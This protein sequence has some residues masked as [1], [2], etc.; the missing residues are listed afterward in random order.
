VEHL[1][2]ILNVSFEFSPKVG[3]RQLPEL[4]KNYQSTV[5]GLY[6]VGDLADAP[7]IKIA[8]NQGY[9]IARHIASLG[10]DDRFDYDCLIVG[11][12]PAGIGGCLALKEAGRRYLCVEKETPFN[13]IQNFPKNKHIFAEP[14]PI[15]AKSG[16]WF[17]DALKEDLVDRWEAEL[18]KHGLDIQQPEEVT[19]IRRAG[20]GFEVVT[21]KAK[22]KVRYV[23]LAIGRRGSVRRA[24]VDGEDLEKVKYALDDADRYR[25]E[26]VMVVGGGDSAVEAALALGATARSVRLCHRGDGFER[27]KP[28]NQQKLKKA[29]DAGKVK[30]LLGCRLVR[31]G[32]RDVTFAA[33]SA[34]GVP[35]EET[36]ANQR[37][38]V[39]I[40]TDLPLPFLKKIGVK[41]EGVWDLKRAAWL[42]LSVFIA[43]VFYGMKEEKIWWPWTAHALDAIRL[44]VGE[45]T[46]GGGFWG[47]VTYS[48]VVTIFGLQAVKK[49]PARHQKIRFASL[50]LSQWFLLFIIPEFVVPGLMRLAHATTHALNNAWR[51]YGL[52]L[53]WPLFTYNVN[54]TNADGTGSLFWLVAG[55]LVTLV[56][57]PI[58]TIFHGKRFCTWICGCGALAETLGDRW[59]HLAPKGELALKLEKMGTVILVVCAGMSGLIVLDTY[60]AVQAGMFSSVQQFKQHYYDVAVD[61]WLSGAIPVGLYP[62][63]G[64]K[65][66]C[67]FWC[68][69]AKYMQITSRL[70]GKLKIQSNDKCIGCGQCSRYCQVGIDVQHFAQRQKPFDNVATSCIQCGICIQV[71]PMDVLSFTTGDG[72]THLNVQS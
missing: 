17:H 36:V 33:A 32:E 3:A 63:F 65:I 51:F 38:F 29:V 50:I 10:P 20:D 46:F 60:H 53:P 15:M 2:D 59:R 70:F 56:V 49:Y 41:M 26:E 18:E 69:L 8:L 57:I 4:D 22:Y 39:L 52:V 27:A 42:I 25:G 30:T 68:P 6:I 58:V 43:Y 71:C 54:A 13:T 37:V 31:I 62:F 19:D 21:Q 40:G 35:V 45:R 64:G 72:K 44:H 47:S 16:L 66:W 28:E 67:R 24:G 1:N 61:F 5:K 7:V 34:G 14:R 55:G 11:A 9:E 12:G 48:L 23:L